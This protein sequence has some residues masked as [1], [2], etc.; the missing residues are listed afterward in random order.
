MAHFAKLN[1]NNIVT[2]VIA[3]HNNELLDDNNVESESKGIDFCN[4]IIPGRWVQASFSNSFRSIFPAPGFSYD[5]EF[6]VFIPPQP[7]PSWKLSY[8]TYLWEAPTPKPEE[9]EGS[10]WKWVESNKEWAAV[11]IIK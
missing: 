2:E 6:D 11:A 1:D 9:V 10:Y 3:V 8:T 4:S 5:Y 7:Y